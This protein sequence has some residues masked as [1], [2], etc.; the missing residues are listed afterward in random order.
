MEEIMETM[1]ETVWKRWKNVQK[2]GTDTLSSQK[3]LGICKRQTIEISTPNQQSP[4]SSLSRNI[5]GFQTNDVIQEVALCHP[6]S[7]AQQ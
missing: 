4:G 3:N 5:S 7:P 2:H 1:L 6:C